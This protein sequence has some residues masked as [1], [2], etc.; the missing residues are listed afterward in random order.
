MSNYFLGGDV[1][2]GYADFVLLD[3]L[4]A[5]AEKHFT[6]DDTALG[7]QGLFHVLRTFCQKNPDAVI[8]AAVESTGGY[9][10][11]WYH[12]LL[13]FQALLNIQTV[14]LNPLGVVHNSKADMKRNNT[15]K[16]SA[17]SIAEYLISH[18]DKIS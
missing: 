7:H 6:L 5:V 3:E 2:K 8:Y 11:N 17:Q 15:D 13:K 12:T 1:S 4:K 10:N 14:R 18:F 16:I 9:E